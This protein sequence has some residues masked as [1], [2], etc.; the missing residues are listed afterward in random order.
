MLRHINSSFLKV[1][2]IAIIFSLI[3]GFIYVAP[4]FIFTQSTFYKGL[5]LMYTDAES[6][7][8]SRTNASYAGCVLSCNPYIKEYKDTFPFHDSSL[9][10]L[11][12]ALPGIVMGLPIF[13]LKIIYEFLLPFILSFLVYS[14]VFRLTKNQWVSIF[15]SVFIVLGYNLFNTT[16]LINISDIFDIFRLKTDY[17]Q[18]LSFSRPVNPQFSSLVFFAYLHILFSAIQKKNL[19]WFCFLAIAC[20]FSFY[21]YFFVYTFIIVIQG[22]WIG[23]YII[24]KEWKTMSNFILTTLAGFIIAAPQFVEIFKLLNHPYY[25]TIPTEYL[26]KTHI[27]EITLIGVLMLSVFVIVSLLYVR[28]FEIISNE[29]Y[30]TATLV[31]VWFI[32][33]NE[34][35]VSGMVMQYSHFEAYLFTPIL[36]IAFCFLVSS[37]LNKRYYWL[38]SLICLIPILNSLL[39]QYNSYQHWLPYAIKEQEYV[40]ILDWLRNE[41]PQGKVISAPEILSELIP[42]YTHNYVLWA[43]WAGQWIHIPGRIEDIYASRSS[44]KEF[45]SVGNKYGVDYYIEEKKSDIFVLNKMTKERVFED[46]NFVVYKKDL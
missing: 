41:I 26:I 10:E 25:S 1:H 46:Q 13:K 32:M 45:E 15:G 37:F 27:P 8:L 43:Y 16:D 44:I 28:K 5:P 17:T 39:I 30:F 2:W 35:V 3:A 40:L 34:H 42:V 36:V 18:F 22:V 38:I 21:V 31:F 23:I 7:Y 29:A 33:R 6:F 11:I 20:G 14:L 4:N 9:S 19:K 12:L 24:R